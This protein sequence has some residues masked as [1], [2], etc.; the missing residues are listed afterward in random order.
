MQNAAFPK[1]ELLFPTHFVRNPVPTTGQAISQNF[2]GLELSAEVEIPLGG[3]TSSATPACTIGLTVKPSAP[4]NA[5]IAWDIDFYWD[6]WDS[7][8]A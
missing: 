8:R 3:T 4:L 1:E 7:S 2:S 6:W 5:H